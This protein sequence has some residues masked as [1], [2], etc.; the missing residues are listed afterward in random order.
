MKGQAKAL[1][2][3]LLLLVAGL[4]PAGAAEIEG[5]MVPDTAKA[6]DAAPELV[7]NGAGVRTRVFFRVYVGALYLQQKWDALI[8]SWQLCN[9]FKKTRADGPC[10]WILVL[11]I[12]NH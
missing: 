5:T 3:A 8:T 6:G 9:V 7:L 2:V 1:S 11:R 4:M 12:V 10:H